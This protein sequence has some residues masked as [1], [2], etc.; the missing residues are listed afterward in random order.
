MVCSLLAEALINLTE[1]YSAH[2]PYSLKILRAK[3][4][5]VE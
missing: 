5:E 4:F 3:V 2:I 1:L